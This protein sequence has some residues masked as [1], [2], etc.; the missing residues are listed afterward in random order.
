MRGKEEKKMSDHVESLKKKLAKLKSKLRELDS[1]IES[2]R[3]VL[4]RIDE[5]YSVPS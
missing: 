1:Y 5:L 4:A 2:V 3:L